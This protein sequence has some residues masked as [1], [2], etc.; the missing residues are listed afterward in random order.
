[1][2]IFKITYQCQI[3]SASNSWITLNNHHQ[4]RMLRYG[5]YHSNNDFKITSLTEHVNAGKFNINIPI[6]ILEY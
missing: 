4:P 2:L 6:L 1:M 3:I 5:N